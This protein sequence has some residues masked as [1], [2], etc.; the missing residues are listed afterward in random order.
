MLGIGV[1]YGANLLLNYAAK[2][3][4]SFI[5][6]VSLGN[7]FDLTKSEINLQEK[8][9]WKPLYN[10]IFKAKVNKLQKKGK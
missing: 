2:Y 3:P 4:D 1:E 8:W 9:A 7:P 6:L 10:D 5:G